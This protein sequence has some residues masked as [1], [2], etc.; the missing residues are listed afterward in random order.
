MYQRGLIAGALAALLLAGASAQGRSDRWGRGELAQAQRLA[1]QLYQSAYRFRSSLGHGRYSPRR[2]A[3]QARDLER[4]SERLSQNL[5]FGRRQRDA[6]SSFI[7]VRDDYLKVRRSFHSDF[8]LDGEAEADRWYAESVRDWAEVADNFGRLRAF[9]LDQRGR[10]IDDRFGDDR[11]GDGRL[12]T[13]KIRCESDDYELKECYV[14]GRVISARVK[15][16]KSRAPCILNR[17][18]GIRGSYL[19]VKDGCDA[20]FR[21]RYRE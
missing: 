11:L 9:A 2:L 10:L 3:S 20:E 1:S 21:V 19:W 7:D 14:G 15:D 13:T 12:R 16:R 17:S 4:S 6:I 18:Y 8:R 5:R